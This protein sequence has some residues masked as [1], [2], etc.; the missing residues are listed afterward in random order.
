VSFDADYDDDTKSVQ[1]DWTLATQVNTDRMVIE[2]SLDGSSW[3]EIPSCDI[4]GAGTVSEE[5]SYSCVHPSP[6]SGVINYYRIVDYD[7]DGRKNL[8]PM[9]S[10]SIP[11]G[12][13]MSYTGSN[14][15]QVGQP[16]HISGV[17]SMQSVEILSMNGS[18]VRSYT[19]VT[20]DM[21]A[22]DKVGMFIIRLVDANGS[23]MSYKI[24]VTE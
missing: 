18:I 8:G 1:L 13:D 2:H 14:P 19:N 5:K 3:S 24:V 16:L 15:V 11:L 20:S 9:Q 17:T 12:K 23:A 21:K 22:P 10:V 6:V 7:Y 4:K